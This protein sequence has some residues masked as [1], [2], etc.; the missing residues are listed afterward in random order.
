MYKLVLDILRFVVSFFCVRVYMASMV[1]WVKYILKLIREL[2]ITHPKHISIL[3]EREREVLVL[4][5]ELGQMS[6][7]YIN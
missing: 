5:H 7:F 2:N 6:L 3:K 1:N 4:R